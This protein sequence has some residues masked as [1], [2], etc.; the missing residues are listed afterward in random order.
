MRVL[1]LYIY[2]YFN[3]HITNFYNTHIIKILHSFTLE[4]IMCEIRVVNEPK[5]YKRLIRNYRIRWQRS[6][7]AKWTKAATVRAPTANSEEKEADRTGARWNER[8]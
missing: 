7:R 2:K 4:T 1:P 6:E 8:V 5:C 3:T